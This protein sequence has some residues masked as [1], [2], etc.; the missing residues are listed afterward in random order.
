MMMIA[1]TVFDFLLLI[2]HV[3]ATF[4]PM[5]RGFDWAV[6]DVAQLRQWLV[7]GRTPREMRALRPDRSLESIKTKIKQLRRGAPDQPRPLSG[8]ERRKCW[9]RLRAPSTQV[10]GHVARRCGAPNTKMS[11]RGASSTS[12]RHD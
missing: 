4:A 9:T 8:G 1:Q 11:K 10:T 5:G 3:F 6:Q 7:D 12:V 2:S